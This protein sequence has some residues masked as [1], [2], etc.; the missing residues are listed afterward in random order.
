[1][2]PAEEAH[3]RLQTGA[4]VAQDTAREALEKD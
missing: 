2:R 1:M 3:E 4:L